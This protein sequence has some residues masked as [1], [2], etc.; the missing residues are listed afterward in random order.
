ML[1]IKV[2]SSQLPYILSKPIHNNQELI[3]K[4]KNGDAKIQLN[5]LINYELISQL[6]GYQSS[7]EILKPQSLRDEIKA[8][9]KSLN[10]T[11]FN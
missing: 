9:I 11:Y 3:K 2:K 5:L 10:N 4:Y 8:I 7:I 6:L 1:I